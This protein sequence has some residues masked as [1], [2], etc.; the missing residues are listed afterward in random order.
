MLDMCHPKASKQA[1]GSLTLK[2]SFLV[3]K[4]PD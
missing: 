1:S 4:A 3:Y 2:N